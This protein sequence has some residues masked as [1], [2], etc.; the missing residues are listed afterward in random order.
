MS[1]P[2]NEERNAACTCYIV[3]LASRGLGSLSFTLTPATLLLP[4]PAQGNLDER[5]TDALVWELMLQAGPV[6]ALTLV[7]R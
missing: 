1:G 5:V 3:S 7:T 4:L 2:R 6:C